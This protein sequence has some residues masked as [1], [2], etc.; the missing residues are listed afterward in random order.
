M[1]DNAGGM[2]HFWFV[3]KT[4]DG[5]ASICMAEEKVSSVNV[6]M[7]ENSSDLEW[8]CYAWVDLYLAEDFI[9]RFMALR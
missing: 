8:F 9:C 6:A 3:K 5:R 2:L 7:R 4:V 1:P